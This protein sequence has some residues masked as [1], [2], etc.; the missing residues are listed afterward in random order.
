MHARI[1]GYKIKV[2]GHP[3]LRVILGLVLIVGGFL[4]F[5]PILGFWM[6]PLGLAVL[7]V[8]FPPVRRFQRRMTIRFGA[9]MHRRYPKQ[10][11]HFGFGKPR[12]GKHD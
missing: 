10:A 11:Q 2:P 9:W 1:A 4:G 5:L 8:D 12:P 7:A 6:I 3:L